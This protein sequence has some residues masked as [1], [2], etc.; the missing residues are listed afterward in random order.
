MVFFLNL[1]TNHSQSSSYRYAALSSYYA[2]HQWNTH[3]R[4]EKRVSSAHTV[5]F[6]SWQS[7]WLDLITVLAARLAQKPTCNH[8]Y[9]LT[10]CNHTPNDVCIIPLCFTVKMDV[11]KSRL[12]THIRKDSCSRTEC[13]A[14]S[15][16]PSFAGVHSTSA[17]RGS[18]DGSRADLKIAKNRSYFFRNRL[19]CAVF[20]NK[21]TAPTLETFKIIRCTIFWNHHLTHKISGPVCQ[22]KKKLI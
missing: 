18:Q 13:L 1:Q 7:S 8:S 6:F 19:F 22:I 16:C 3:F 14:N 12:E 11:D 20:L 9:Q 17:P 21:S 10:R 4:K 2:F 15:G 5:Q